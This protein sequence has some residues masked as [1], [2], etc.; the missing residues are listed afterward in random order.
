MWSMRW[1]GRWSCRGNEEGVEGRVRFCS[2]IR[3]RI[4]FVDMIL[5]EVEI[6]P[7]EIP[8][9]T[10]WLIRCVELEYAKAFIER[11]SMKFT[12]PSEWCKPDGTSRWDIF[13]GIYASQRGLDSEMDRFLK[14]LR[15]DVFTIVDGG[16]TYY[17]SREILS[18]RAHCLYGL[19]SNNMHMQNVRSQDHRFHQAGRVTKEYFHNL[20]PKVNREAIENLEDNKK[21]AVLLI[22]PDAFV[23]FVKNRFLEKGVKEE[24]IIIGPVSYHDY[25]KKPFIIGNDPEELFSKHIDYQEQSEIRIV[26]NTRRKEV[27]DLFDE[28][29][30]IELGAVD[31]S[32]AT[33]SDFYFDD[34]QVE[35]RGNELLYSLAKPQVYDIDEIDDV[36]LLT[37]IQQA[38]SDELPKAPMTIGQ[39][40]QWIND[41]LHVLKSR[42]PHVKYDWFTNVI[43]YKGVFYDLGAKAGYKILEHYNTYILDGDIKSAGE[44]VEKFKHFFPSYDMGNYFSAYYRAIGDT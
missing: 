35:I 30:V 38:L 34:M 40:E 20:F 19:N 8:E 3:E 10:Y 44:T 6:I 36:S 12:H 43:Y 11:G 7:R 33:I 22:K 31:K 5:K 37:I 2:R 1:K 32:I 17:K 25:Y 14:T 28:Y 27:S 39:I 42:D 29:G 16:F 23:A 24:E 26:I 4:S 21:P 15:N 18:Y 13:E 9:H 41:I